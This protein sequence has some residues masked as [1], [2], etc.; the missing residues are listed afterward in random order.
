MEQ[1]N[2]DTRASMARNLIEAIERVRKDVAKVELWAYAVT[3]FAQ[4]IPDYKPGDISVWLPREQATM[5]KN[6]EKS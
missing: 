1:N 2:N 3:G 6:S 4:P 5:L